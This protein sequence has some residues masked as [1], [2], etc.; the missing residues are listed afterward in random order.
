M[1]SAVSLFNYSIA[2]QLYQKSHIH[3]PDSKRLLDTYYSEQSGRLE[4][5]ELDTPDSIS[6]SDLAP[7]SGLMPAHTHG[8][9]AACSGVIH[10]MDGADQSSAVHPGRP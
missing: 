7:Q 9:G 10:G 6:I 8:G 3:S 4:L 1:F 2:C 5:Y